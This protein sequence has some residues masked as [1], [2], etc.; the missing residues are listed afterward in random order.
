MWAGAS[1]FLA[2]SPFFLLL[3]WSPVE[4]R[5]AANESS[6]CSSPMT[7]CYRSQCC[8]SRNATK[9]ACLL[10]TGSIYAQ[11]RPAPPTGEC[12][13]TQSWKCPGWSHENATS[14][15][16]AI[17]SCSWCETKTDPWSK[18]CGWRACRGCAVC[19]KVVTQKAVSRKAKAPMVSRWTAVAIAVMA[20]G[21]LV[22]FFFPLLRQKFLPAV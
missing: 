18:K 21:L 22:G 13:D 15:V 8:K 11:C 7:N 16:T 12:I 9:Y 10:R 3:A 14:N 6:S 17:P 4:S 1:R 2:T 20:L 5:P 19:P